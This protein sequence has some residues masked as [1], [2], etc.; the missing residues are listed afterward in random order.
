MVL[1][2]QMQ[3]REWNWIEIEINYW[4]ILFSMVLL[5]VNVMLEAYKWYF[6]T[7]KFYHYSFSDVLQL[8]LSGRSMN[9]LAPAGIGDAILRVGDVDSNARKKALAALFFCRLTQLM[10]TLFFGMLSVAFLIRVGANFSLASSYLWGAIVL[11]FVLAIC[12]WVFR[13]SIRAFV[14]EFRSHIS[15]ISVKVFHSLLGLSFIRYLVFSLQFLLVLLAVGVELPY[16]LLVFGVFWIFLSKSLVPGMLLVGDL[17]TREVSAILFFSFF[18][19]DIKP[20]VLGALIVWLINIVFPAI[21]GLFYV[22]KAKR[23]IL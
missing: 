20:F 5:P 4:M 23:N 7:K 16:Y 15:F 3:D 12:H 18:A 13:F 19:S 8:I 22:S 14:H 17:M 21:L 2:D 9:V 6:I 11:V 1:Y 10:P